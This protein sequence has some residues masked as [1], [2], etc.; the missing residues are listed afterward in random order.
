MTARLFDVQVANTT[1][2][3]YTPRWLFDAMQ[4]EFDIDVCA[5]AGGLP[6]IPARRSY[7]IADD[8]LASAWDGLVWCN[9]PYSDPGPW[10][11]K[12]A[13][14]PLGMILLRADLSASGQHAAFDAAHAMWVPA[15]RLQFVSGCEVPTGSVN[16]T[17]VLLARGAA[18]TCALE[19]LSGLGITRRLR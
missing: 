4:V 3:W 9:P 11:R 15:K 14:H 18:A 13:T 1:D 6:W 2:D 16:F 7:S 17:S 12:W 8:G 10:C 19:R 5:P